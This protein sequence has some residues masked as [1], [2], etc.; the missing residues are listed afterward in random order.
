MPRLSC[1]F[2]ITVS[3]VGAPSAAGI[4]ELGRVVE[5]ALTE[6]LRL[7]RRHLETVT[8]R[9][10]AAMSE[11]RETEDPARVGATGRVYRVPSYE[12]GGALKPV[13]LTTD[14]PQSRDPAPLSDTE[15]DAEYLHARN[16]L[17]G[18]STVEPAHAGIK[19]YAE[20][21]E[22]ELHRRS[23][24]AAAGPA[25]RTGP[26]VTVTGGRPTGRPPVAPPAVV[27]GG[28]ALPKDRQYR[29]TASG[30]GGTYGEHDLPHLLGERGVHAVITS[31]GPGAH[32][33]NEP[34]FD[35]VG[36]QRGTRTVWLVDNKALNALKDI[37]GE[38]ATALG[39]NLR[40]S[41][42][43]AI[44]K[45]RPIAEF[46]GKADLVHRLE[47]ARDAVRAGKPIP[48]ELNVKLAVTNAGGYAT[49]A[50]NLP[51]QAEFVDLVG[52][53]ARAARAADIAA[54]ES[55]GVSPTRPR[56]HADTE[57][58]RRQVGG[59]LSRRPVRVRLGV[60]IA[61]SL[62]SAGR[63]LAVIGAVVIWNVAMS[64]V[65]QAIEDWFLNRWAKPKL[66]ALEPEIQAR[67][68][69]RL[70]ELVDLQLRH[71]GK[72]L[73]AVIGVLITL[74]R[75]GEDDTELESADLRLT[76]VSV[77]AERVEHSEV[78]HVRTHPWHGIREV[79]DLIRT[80]YSV[81]LDPLGKAEL[82]TVLSAEIAAE[83]E[84]VGARSATPEQ[85]RASQRRRD[86]L[87]AQLKQVEQA[88]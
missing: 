30:A 28:P 80:T 15:L 42:E 2:P 26:T 62:K 54:A 87:A 32:R 74:E 63:G 21:L 47:A 36:I 35:F 71:P 10:P 86:Q 68:D 48:A 52:A 34:G 72:T 14:A 58:M 29:V 81:E 64:Y 22:A 82:A 12:D 85:Q 57:R 76:S 53:Q 40:A 11:A 27:G 43:R 45:I 41:L 39:V 61:S 78:E 17:L 59:A 5:Q 60:R 3:V 49:G 69:D 46:E 70:E 38:S 56:S 65:N 7:A 67:L 79:R 77:A 88:P 8:G 66:A 13:R 24:A 51:P 84:A 33:P 31:S 25:A 75:A 50:R 20:A 37:D 23:S 18:H 4:E 73:Y 1:H 55:A 9:E 44:D 6:R 83:E 19:A 16:W